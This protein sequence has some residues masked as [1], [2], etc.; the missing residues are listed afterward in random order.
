MTI[1]LNVTINLTKKLQS[2]NR[3]TA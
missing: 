3:L 1:V 2:A